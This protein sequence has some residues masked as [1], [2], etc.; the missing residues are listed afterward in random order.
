[1]A[2]LK[3]RELG[4]GYTSEVD[5]VDE[6]RWCEILQEFD[7]ASIYQTWSYAAVIGGRRNMS[8]LILRENGDIAA[9]AQA[10]IARLPFINVGI[11]YIRWGPLWRRGATEVNVDTFR[12]AVRAL[13]NEF[14]CKRGLVLR[15]FPILFDDDSPCFSA[16]LAEEG[17]SSLGKKTRDRTILIDLSPPLEDLRRGMRRNCK[18]NLKQAE[19]NGLQVVEGSEEE[20]FAAFIDIYKEM[21]SRKKF[22]EPNDMN[23]F[24]LIQTQLP[25]KLKMKVMLCKSGEGVCA[26]VVW[27]EIGKMAVGLFSA[28][29]NTGMKS[30]GS[31]LL[32]WEIIK[33]LKQNGFA[34]HDLNGINPIRNPRGYMFKSD[35]AGKNGKDVYDLGRFDSHANV[36]SYS[37]VVCGDSLRTLYRTLREKWQTGLGALRPHDPGYSGLLTPRSD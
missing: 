34:V 29:S 21:V 22:A 32:Q 12:Q 20:L 4:P 17:F 2:I 15:L 16:I 14:V 37:C 6:R 28:T 27:S 11:A 7:D 33:K 30:S 25:E 9:V 5:T 35:L 18:Y 8:H 1:M 36:L 10:R 3:M 24:R 13:R 23:Q 31:Y 19:R 26:G